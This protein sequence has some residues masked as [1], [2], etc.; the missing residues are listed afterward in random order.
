MK[1]SILSILL[2]L[3]IS[4]KAQDLLTLDDAFK[5]ALENNL[6]IKIEEEN[7]QKA[8]NEYTR[9]NAGYLPDIS[10]SA[11]YD[12]NL[13]NTD[14]VYDFGVAGDES[15]EGGS[16][17]G[18]EESA[19]N[20]SIGGDGLSSESYQVSVSMSYTLFEGF[21]KRYRY[22]QL[23][24]YSEMGANQLQNQI[25]NSLIQVATAYFEIARQQA[26]LSLSKEKVEISKERVERT[27]LNEQFGNST[28]LAYLQSLAYLN[29]DSIDYRSSKVSLVNAKRNLNFL[30]GRSSDIE[31]NVEST[32][33]LQTK[34]SKDSLLQNALTNNAYIKLSQ[35]QLKIIK[36]DYSIA[37]SAYLP[38][39]SMSSS[40]RH[41]NQEN[42]QSLIVSQENS[43]L[44]S[45]LTLS[46]PIFTGGRRKNNIQSA[47]ININKQEFTVDKTKGEI[48]KELLNTYEQYEFAT[49]QLEIEKKN[50][51][52]YEDSF[53]KANNDFVNGIVNSTEVRESQNN[54]IN[55]K[56]RVYNLTYNVKLYELILQQ[57]AGELVKPFK[58]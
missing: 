10:L 24:G 9:G 53:N 5:I 1:V 4:V 34:L 51:K 32:L 6:D 25:E 21:A 52:L 29:T 37:K 36:L 44:Y 16:S 7:Y 58:N 47:K 23:E 49:S 14:A 22:K 19:G 55:A 11:N 2:V 17:S 12:N 54:L 40:Y 48:E 3:T 57:L 18:A 33:L 15:Q 30:L 26:A 50:L 20:T 43:G 42:E 31:F 45:G 41:L 27:R 56:N 38:T 28:N 39:L 8:L 13:E 46:L 35:E